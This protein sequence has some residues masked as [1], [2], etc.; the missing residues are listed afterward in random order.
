MR[1]IFPSSEDRDPKIRHAGQWVSTQRTEYK[2]GK[3]SGKRIKKLEQIEEWSWDALSDRWNTIYED[4]VKFVKKNKYPSQHDEDPKRRS[5]GIWIRTLRK[6]YRNGTLS[7]NWIRKLETLPGWSWNLY[8]DQLDQTYAE[9]L[10]FV[11]QKKRLPLVNTKNNKE[12]SLGMWIQN[13]RT[14][15]RQGKLSQEIIEKLEQIPKW[16]WNPYSSQWDK[17]CTQLKTFIKKNKKLP[18][19][20]SNSGTER[21]LGHWVRTQRKEH[22]NLSKNRIK[23]LE[24]IL[25]WSW[26]PYHQQ[27]DSKYQGVLK[28]SR[29]GG[30]PPQHSKNKEE[31]HLSQWISQQRTKQR[32]GKL[33][34]ERIKQLEQIPGWFWSQ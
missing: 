33:S 34:Q 17:Q 5:M 4:L 9:A 31:R 3:L 22:H 27:W 12:K 20:H 26:S 6:V 23:Q 14:A 10:L 30:L 1:I 25:E 8:I 19:Q 15:Y 32:E 16:E 24:A 13:K 11:R 29:M 18:S 28:S 7:K 21:N 2:K